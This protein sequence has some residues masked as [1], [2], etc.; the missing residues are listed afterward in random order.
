MLDDEA[1]HWD[2]VERID[3]AEVK[4][5]DLHRRLWKEG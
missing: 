1:V 3:P 4:A 2:L 5:D